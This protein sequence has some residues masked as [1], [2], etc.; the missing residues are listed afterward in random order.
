M[1]AEEKVRS[2]NLLLLAG[3][4]PYSASRFLLLSPHD[5]FTSSC[6]QSICPQRIPLRKPLKS[7]SRGSTPA[8]SMLSCILEGRRGSQP[9]PPLSFHFPACKPPLS[10]THC[11]SWMLCGAELWDRG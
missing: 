3:Q 1:Q 10:V 9:P 8:H 7:P 5:V 11:D 6:L 4:Q 2:H